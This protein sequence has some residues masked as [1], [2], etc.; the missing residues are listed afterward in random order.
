MKD[1]RRVKNISFEL[2]SRRVEK[3][4]LILQMMAAVQ[5][6]QIEFFQF[7]LHAED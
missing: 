7:I 2:K 3:A 5:M 6:L 1:G 4:R